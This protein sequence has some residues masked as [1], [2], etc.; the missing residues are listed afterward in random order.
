MQCTTN[1]PGDECKFMGKKGCTF[2]GG[3][4]FQ[5][6]EKCEGCNKIVETEV[7]RFCAVFPHPEMKWKRGVCNFASHVKPE[8]KQDASGKAINPLKA[9]KRASRGR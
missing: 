3:A 2:L 6:V 1:R 8:I 5:I 4:C 9:A 7:G